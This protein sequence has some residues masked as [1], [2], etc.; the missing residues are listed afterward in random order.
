M[1][2]VVVPCFNEAN[3]IVSAVDDIVALCDRIDLEV[4]VIDDGSSDE[5]FSKLSERRDIK[6]QR[7]NINLGK[8]AAIATGTA[9]AAGDIIVIH[10][11]DLEY[12]AEAIPKLIE[13]ILT[14]KSDIV[15]GSRFK[16]EIDEMSFS[17][18]AGNK[19]L[20]YFTSLLCG[21]SV[22]DMMTGQK[23]FR[24]N[25]FRSLHLEARRFEFEV[26]VTVEALRRGY[27]ILEVPIPYSRRKF[28]EAKITWSDGIRTMLRLL[29]C[30]F[31]I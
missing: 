14:G 2:S 15:Y 23:A 7:H 17:H 11:A 12:D 1:I 6:L 27:S 8:G 19:V 25:V 26:E 30:R 21:A 31:A 20:S 5:S 10:D 29:E 24:T 28:G 22:S 16:G 18:Y 3:T 4:I 9:I 13:P